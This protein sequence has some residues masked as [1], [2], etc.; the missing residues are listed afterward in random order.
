MTEIY[1]LGRVIVDLY[2]NQL[3]TPLHEV[4]SFNKY[5]GGSAGNH[6]VGLARL[7]AR[8]GLISRVGLD[9]FGTFLLGRLAAEGVDTGMVGRDPHH[10][11]G[12][13]FAAIFPPGDSKVLFYRKP[14]ADI[15]LEIGDLDRPALSQAR[16]L[17]TTGTALAT[18]PSRAAALRAMQLMRAAGGT[19]II[20]VDWRPM[21]WDDRATAETY[22][23]LALG[24]TDI[25][26]ANE[27]EL[28]F[29]GRTGQT[30]TAAARVLALGPRQLV[31]KRGAQGVLLYGEEGPLE[32]PPFRVEVMNTLGA[33]D[34]F[35]AGFAYSL[36]QGWHIRRALTFAAA[37]GA[38]VVSRHSCSEAMPH[39]AEVE[40]L[41]ADQGEGL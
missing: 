19:N 16:I 9:D 2:A 40:R 28:E 20:D 13:A 7:G 24:L 41:M 18:A 3:N 27:P 10:P 14:C 31:A 22:Y 25:V 11:T 8:A 4:A 12:L 5:L 33:G 32:V 38:I 29:I 17:I 36:L 34:G 30:D 26:V 6:A 35:G 39:R 15:H 37:C 1:T 23:D 21:L